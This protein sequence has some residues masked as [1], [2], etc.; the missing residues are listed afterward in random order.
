MVGAESNALN[1]SILQDYSGFFACCTGDFWV[2]FSPKPR[3]RGEHEKCAHLCL[4]M[5]CCLSVGEACATTV[6]TQ[7]TRGSNP[8][9]DAVK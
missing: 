1:A 6:V 3:V 5:C 8:K 7:S 9:G 4:I 2:L